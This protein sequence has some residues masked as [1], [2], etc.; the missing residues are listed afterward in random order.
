MTPRSKLLQLTL[1][2]PVLVLTVCAPES[3]DLSPPLAQPAIPGS[4]STGPGQ[5]DGDP[6]DVLVNMFSRTDDA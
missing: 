2:P 5:S 1:L 4:A 3:P 6:L